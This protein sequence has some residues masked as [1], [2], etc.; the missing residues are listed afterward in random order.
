MSQQLAD[1]ARRHRPGSVPG[2]V[3]SDPSTLPVRIRII[4]YDQHTLEEVDITS[5]DEIRKFCDR[6][7]VTWVNVDGLRD[8]HLISEIGEIFGIHRLVLEDIV[9]PHQRAKVETFEGQTVIV[10]RMPELSHGFDT[11]QISMV[12]CDQAVITFQERRGDCLDPVRNR[13]RSRLGRIC[14]QD[15]DY[16]VYALL[17]AIIDA[18]FPVLSK[19]GERLDRVERQMVQ[20]PS[21]DVVAILQRIRSLLFVI[22]GILEPHQI[23]VAH[24]LRSNSQFSD[25]TRIYL[26]DCADH[27]NQVLHACETSRELAADL[28][29]YCFAELSFNQNETMKTLTVMASVF[30]PLSFIAGFYGMN[31]DPAVSS[32]NMPETRW[33]YGYAFAIT[34]MVAVATLTLGGLRWLAISRRKA[35]KRRFRKSQQLLSE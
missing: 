8:T 2:Q 26:R 3:V 16:L 7:E 6:P 14:S 35:R 20:E 30:I 28:R 23:A 4:Q 19:I 22:R 10:A 12:L 25:D 29:D 34:L 11:E 17:D 5:T 32:W 27:L 31:F 13:I 18:Y 15:Q 1:V 9:N 24:L 33:R 21:V